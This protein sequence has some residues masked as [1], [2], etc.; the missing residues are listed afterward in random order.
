MTW[1]PVDAAATAFLDLLK[2][3]GNASPAP[4]IA[5]LNL[6]HPRP[7]PWNDLFKSVADH[8]QL[9]FIPYNKWTELLRSKANVL[10]DQDHEASTDLTG[11]LS[12]DHLGAG[13]FK[14]DITLENCPSLKDV[15][16]LEGEDLIKCLDFWKF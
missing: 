9:D 4:P 2:H 13:K 14:L 6:V 15:K 1:L 11:F 12:G 8:L 7:T 16:A 5:Y 10:A 3:S